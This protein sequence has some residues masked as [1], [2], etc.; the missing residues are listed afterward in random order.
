MLS[1]VS[2]AIVKLRVDVFKRE[3]GSRLPVFFIGGN[4]KLFGRVFFICSLN[5]LK[6]FTVHEPLD[7]EN[8]GI[9]V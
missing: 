9:S 4:V 7:V 5:D 3:I 6:G 8:R 1:N 2:I